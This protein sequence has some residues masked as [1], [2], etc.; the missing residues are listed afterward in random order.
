M[1]IKLIFKIWLEWIQSVG[2][3][4]VGKKNF[5]VEFIEAGA[6]EMPL[7]SIVLILF[8]FLMELEM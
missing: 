6:A 8:L 1:K 2:M 5:D 3:M 4:D 7:E